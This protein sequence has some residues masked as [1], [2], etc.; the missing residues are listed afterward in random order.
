[1]TYAPRSEP[2]VVKVDNAKALHWLESGAQPT[3]RVKTLLALSGAW[4]EYE[5]AQAARAAKRTVKPARQ[6]PAKGGAATKKAPAK[7]AAAKP[8][9]AKAAEADADDAG[10]DES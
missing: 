6:R 9:A 7:K 8:V 4:G 5:S 3:D 2:S 1:G 10:S